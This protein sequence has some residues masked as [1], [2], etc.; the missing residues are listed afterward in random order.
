M[1]KGVC[2][3]HSQVISQIYRS[4][5]LKSTRQEV[6]LNFSTLHWLSGIIY[7][8]SG[9]LYG[10][11]RVITTKPFDADW[12]VELCNRYQVTT[13]L[14]APSLLIPL[15]RKQSFTPIDSV[16]VLMIGGSIMPKGLC[17]S[18]QRLFPNSDICPIYAMTE[19]D[20]VVD[21]FSFK[22]EDSVGK[23]S[24]NAHI[25]IIDDAGNNLAPNQRGEIC[26]RTPV[27]F[28][29]YFGDHETTA[30]AI[31]DGWIYS[32]DIGYF[33]DDGF[34]FV[35]DRKKDLLK[36]NSYQVSFRTR[37]EAVTF[38]HFRRFVRRS[39]KTSFARSAELSARAWSAFSMT[40]LATIS[41][42][43]SW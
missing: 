35:V 13:S 6:L 9:T 30:D 40:A 19:V 23:V 38:A 2:K 15:L 24:P 43:G 42:L 10:G 7:L 8:L 3:S 36:F 12:L 26:I 17:Q 33:N 27:T 18:V 31:K 5:A 29:G 25:K 39:L 20:V 14:I 32:G 22:L 34:C 28:S 21:S 11:K 16:E 4:W 37:S 1:V 41:S